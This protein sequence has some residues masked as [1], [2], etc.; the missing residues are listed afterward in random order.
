MCSR[1]STSARCVRTSDSVLGQRSSQRNRLVGA[2]SARSWP[3]EF[4]RPALLMCFQLP[5]W[6]KAVSVFV[7]RL[8]SIKPAKNMQMS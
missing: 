6:F 4:T 1:R 3:Q 8:M 2:P 7:L 5:E